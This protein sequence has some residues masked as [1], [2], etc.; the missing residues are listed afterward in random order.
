MRFIGSVR[1][2]WPTA[3]RIIV[4][5]VALSAVASCGSPSITQPSEVSLAGNWSGSLVGRGPCGGDWSSLTLTLDA[6]GTGTL[7]TADG[8]RFPVTQTLTSDV[9]GLDVTLPPGTGECGTI[10]LIV[11]TVEARAATQ[12]SGFSGDVIGRCCGTLQATYHFARR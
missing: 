1:V 9:R 2:A 10:S 8:Q 6:A 3:C 12:A 7:T 11:S 5:A 4:C